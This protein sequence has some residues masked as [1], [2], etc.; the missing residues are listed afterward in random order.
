MGFPSCLDYS[1][2][3]DCS[4]GIYLSK[5]DRINVLSWLIILL[6]TNILECN[7]DT[8]IF[9]EKIDNTCFDRSYTFMDQR[10]C[11]NIL[12]LSTKLNCC[13]FI[14]SLYLLVNISIIFKSICSVKQSWVKI[15]K[16]ALISLNLTNFLK[17]Y[18]YID[19]ITTIFL[20]V[21]KNKYF[22]YFKSNF[23]VYE[24]SL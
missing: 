9:L 7:M 3:H 12:V 23:I 17:F 14:S 18:Y 24:W 22:F 19:K 16:N 20:W 21:N 1:L 5:Q 13:L 11:Y 15:N 10:C 2:Y 6:L 4:I 8:F